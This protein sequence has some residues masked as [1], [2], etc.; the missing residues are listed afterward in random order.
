MRSSIRHGGG[1]EAVGNR[2]TRRRARRGSRDRCPTRRGSPVRPRH[3]GS[4]RRARRAPARKRR[5]GAPRSARPPSGTIMRAFERSVSHCVDG[6]W[7]AAWHLLR[8]TGAE[9]PPCTVTAEYAVTLKRPTP[10]NAPLKLRAHVVESSGDKVIVEAEL[11]GGGKV[12]AT[13]KGTFVA[14]KP[15]H[16]AY[17]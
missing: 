11:I 16:P 4:S 5:R 3:R 17:H 15:G 8:K 12:C 10:S 13:C 2:S 14:V 9:T 1:G 6:R 7:S